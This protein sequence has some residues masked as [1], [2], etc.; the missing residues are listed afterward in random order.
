LP[1]TRFLFWNINRKPLADAVAELAEE[2]A[3]D[4]VVLVESDLDPRAMLRTL[5]TRRRGEFHLP[6]GLSKRVTIFTRFSRQFLRPTFESGYISIRRL[7][8]PARSE[9]LVVAVHLPSKL[10]Q[11]ADS[12]VLECAELAR[13]ISGEEDRAGHRRTVV[14]G[15]FNMNPFESGLVGAAGLNSVMSRQIASLASRAVQ[16]KDY[17]F[18]TIRCGGTSVIRAPIP[19][20]RIFTTARSM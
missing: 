19:P 15:D 13:Q 1:S 6:R 10:H 7:A 12:Q 5:N 17:P 2:H 9:L 18:F 3:V 14:L 4:I 20:D 11:P 8:L 16:G